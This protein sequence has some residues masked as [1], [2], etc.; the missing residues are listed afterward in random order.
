MH[1]KGV[2]DVAITRGEHSIL[3]SHSEA[4]GEVHVE[5]IEVVDTLGAG[6]FFHGAFS[7]YYVKENNFEKALKQASK[8]A[9]QS[10]QSFGTR[11]WMEKN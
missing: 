5:N 7:H 9:A 1:R 11:Q 3:F 2:R 8:I 4:Q 6:D 10:C